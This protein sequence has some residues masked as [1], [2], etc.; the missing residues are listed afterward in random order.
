MQL[1]QVRKFRF[2]HSFE[3]PFVPQNSNT[4]RLDILKLERDQRRLLGD[5]YEGTLMRLM[6]V[7]TEE[8]KLE[9]SNSRKIS[10]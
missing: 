4:F 5:E 2:D 1:D 10:L 9:V 6:A 8:G 3:T 7:T